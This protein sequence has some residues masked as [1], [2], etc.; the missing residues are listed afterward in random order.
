[1]QTCGKFK[2]RLP[3]KSQCKTNLTEELIPSQST[4]PGYPGHLLWA[5]HPPDKSKQC[6]PKPGFIL[7]PQRRLTH[8]NT[9]SAFNTDTDVYFTKHRL[10]I[11]F[12]HTCN[13][14][15]HSPRG[16]WTKMW[17]YCRYNLPWVCVCNLLPNVT[18]ALDEALACKL[19]FVSV[20]SHRCADMSDCNG[21]MY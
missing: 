21:N 10:D 3:S 12:H 5:A 1:M 13:H 7:H 14:L 18:L 4:K 16:L 19:T 8:L 6:C 11:L 20:H 15:T 2:S 9:G 17:F